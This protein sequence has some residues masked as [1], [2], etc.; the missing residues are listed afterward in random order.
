MT[1][2]TSRLGRTY[3]GASGA[4]GPLLFLRNT[5]RVALGE[6]VSVV[7][8]GIAPRRGQVI[9]AGESMTVVQV[10]EETL[11]LAPAST[12]ITLTGEVGVGHGGSRAAGP[13]PERRGA[14][15]R[16]PA[17]AGRRG[18]GLDHRRSHEPGPPAPSCGSD[19]RTPA[20]CGSLPTPRS[21]PAFLQAI[22][23]ARRAPHGR[24]CLAYRF[25]WR[26]ATACAGGGW[27]GGAAQAAAS[28]AW[29]GGGWI[30]LARQ[31]RCHAP[32]FWYAD[33][34]LVAPVRRAGLPGQISPRRA[35]H[36]L[37]LLAQGI[38]PCPAAMRHSV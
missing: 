2:I 27:G 8:P 32:V 3:H 29:A 6:W 4:S 24:R 1:A 26:V 18:A 16:R 28:R 37:R 10:L 31:T 19:G 11:G 13:G 38:G 23:T 22:V 5:H 9:D 15:A 30:F 7:T 14:T 33:E 21:W 36:A 34:R 20:R 25:G 12:A 17:R 35:G